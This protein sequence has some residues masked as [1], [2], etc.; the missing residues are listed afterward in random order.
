MSVVTKLA[1]VVVDPVVK[2]AALATN[3]ALGGWIVFGV[4]FLC[5]TVYLAYAGVAAR[6]FRLRAFRALWPLFFSLAAC[7][8]YFTIAWYGGFVYTATWTDTSVDPAVV[9]SF[10]TEFYY[11]IPGAI[12]FYSLFAA[13]MVSYLGNHDLAW[14]IRTNKKQ[15]MELPA[16][17][18][19]NDID[20]LNNSTDHGITSTGWLVA[21]FEFGMYISAAF[22][23]YMPD[24]RWVFIGLGLFC[25]VILLLCYWML[26]AAVARTKKI[27]S[28][29]AFN[30]SKN[31]NYY[32]WWQ[33]IM[34]LYFIITKV[35]FVVAFCLGPSIA[36]AYNYSFS[37]I[38]IAYL[39]FN[40][41]VWVL[42]ITMSARFDV[43]RGWKAATA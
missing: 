10:E 20:P 43:T 18:T 32:S 3:T 23:T 24:A 5:S 30:L 25:W 16:G 41:A 6:G 19:I 33:A 7:F 13:V 40:C 1:E 29:K 4:L 17:L 31:A 14:L 26:Y 12:I 21:S 8:V 28:S 2:T 36:T 34:V 37:T 9:T 42:W 38:M 22:A 11:L 15:S 27:L 35:G 39:I